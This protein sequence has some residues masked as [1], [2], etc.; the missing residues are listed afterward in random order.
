MIIIQ[1]NKSGNSETCIRKKGY[2]VDRFRERERERERDGLERCDCA[3]S[4]PH[5]VDDGFLDLW[6]GETRQ[7]SL[8]FFLKQ[9]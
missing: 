9:F 8:S 3:L 2:V 1:L 7:V 5:A 4:H 6:G